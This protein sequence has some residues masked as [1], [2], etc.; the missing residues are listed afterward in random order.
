MMFIS[1]HKICFH[2]KILKIRKKYLYRQKSGLNTHGT[3]ENS[4]KKEEFELLGLNWVQTRAKEKQTRGSGEPV[5]LT[6]IK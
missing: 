4:F 2:W 5:S 1:L 6:W 3:N